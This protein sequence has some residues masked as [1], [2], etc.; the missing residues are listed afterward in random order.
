MELGN[1]NDSS[2]VSG[3]SESAKENS[4]LNG[5]IV[6]QSPSKKQ[7]YALTQITRV[8]QITLI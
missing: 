3:F 2:N 5:S 8:H 4:G 7:R 6:I 1:S